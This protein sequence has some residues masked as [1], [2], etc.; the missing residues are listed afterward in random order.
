MRLPQASGSLA[1]RDGAPPLLN[2]RG[3]PGFFAIDVLTCGDGHTAGRK[4]RGT[5]NGVRAAGALGMPRTVQALRAGRRV[6]VRVP[7]LFAGPAPA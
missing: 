7:A 4:T 6:P 2:S 3:S 1:R 5:Y